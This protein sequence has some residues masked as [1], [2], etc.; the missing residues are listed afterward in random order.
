MWLIKSFKKQRETERT[1]NDKSKLS[2]KNLKVSFAS[3]IGKVRLENEDNFFIEGIGCKTKENFSEKIVV[4]DFKIRIFA[5]FDGMGGEAYGK[6]ASTI[7]AETLEKFN[8]DFSKAKDEDIN[9]IVQEYVK[10]ANEE[11]CNMI[12]QKRCTIGGCTMALVCILNGKAY[13]FSIGDS[14]IY[15]YNQRL[16]QISEDQ[17]LAMKKLKANIYTEEEAKNSDDARKLTSYLGVDT[18]NTGISVLA[19][20]PFDIADGKI[21]ICS[22]GLTDM[23]SDDEDK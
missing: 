17:T 8:I 14:R 10:K 6:E 23:C 19:Y 21:L 1:Q 3:N 5:V 7:A 12:I 4:S 22:D 2:E 16:K 20:S 9:S 13:A 15:Y 11:I 18:R